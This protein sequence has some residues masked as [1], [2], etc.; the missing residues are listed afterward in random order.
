MTGAWTQESRWEC[1]ARH[2]RA[3]LRRTGASVEDYSVDVLG[4]WQ[5]RTPADVRDAHCADFKQ[6]GSGYKLMEA[7]GKK[8][9]RWL[10]PEVSARP[11]VD[12][13]ECL[14][15]ALPEPDRS[16]CLRDLAARYGGLFVAVHAGVDLSI[17]G[18][19]DL[20]RECGEALQ[21]LSPLLVD[22]QINAHDDPQLL[23]AARSELLDVQSA[24][25]AV[26]AR[27]DAALERAK[28][29]PAAG[30]SGIRSVK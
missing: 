2:V 23:A 11:S 4:I 30:R 1:T 5:Q 18:A 28:Q 24:A 27:I 8:I 26:I 10:N 13:E 6:T 12:V 9:R 16:H 3:A 21:S 20:M 22:G 15:L 29:T 19:A 7:N 14:V 25:A 17:G